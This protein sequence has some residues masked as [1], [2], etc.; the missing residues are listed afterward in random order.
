MTERLYYQDAYLR[1]FQAIVVELLSWQAQPA[2][3]LKRSAFYPTGGGQPHDTGRLDGVPVVE[4]IE[5]EADGAVIH[6]LE[7]LLPRDDPAGQVVGEVDWTR[8]FDHMQQHSGQHILSRA[9]ERLFDAAT[10]G[11]HLGKQS[12][13]IDLDRTPLDDGPI[14]QLEAEANRIVFENRP[15]T[16][17][18]VNR[19]QLNG[20]P[21]RKPPKVSGPIRIVEVQDFDWSPCGGTHVRASG[22]VGLIKIVRAERRG[23][24]TRL[25]FLCGGR[26]LADYD[27]KNRLLLSLASQLSVGYWQLPEVVRRL[28]EEARAQRKLALLAQEQLLAFEAA[29]LARQ[30]EPLGEF[31]LVSRVW[32]GKNLEEARRL[33]RQLSA[34]HG[35]VALL[36]LAGEK[37][38][39]IFSAPPGAPYDLRP[40]LR[41]A[42][43][44]IGGGGG[45][46]ADLAQGGGPV[47]EWPAVQ[48]AL[49]VAADII[50]CDEAAR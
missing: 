1:Q 49:T 40:A 2:V 50:R 47:G 14:G 30:A 7:R 41:R 26:A 33:A 31:G 32:Q 22:E 15:V 9:A 11:F 5:R 45:G 46:R 28:E 35:C 21:L 29:D 18:F 13:T 39:L 17:R 43:A 38:H 16:A 44:I 36:G 42:C 19:E 34:A 23:S 37:G 20:L 27:L 48:A 10:V 6:V 12:C 25:E 3:V 4:V 24:E 8:R